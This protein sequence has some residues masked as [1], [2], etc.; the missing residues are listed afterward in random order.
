MGIFTSTKKALTQQTNQS[1]FSH[2]K[3]LVSLHN[4]AQQTHKTLKYN[5]IKNQIRQ[6][7]IN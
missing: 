6:K 1:Q 4:K 5:P 2:K 7:R 3:H